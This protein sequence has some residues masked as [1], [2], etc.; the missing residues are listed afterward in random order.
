[1]DVGQGLKR[2]DTGEFFS[3]D[4]KTF[5]NSLGLSGAYSLTML[6]TIK[7]DTK[8]LETSFDAAL[9]RVPEPG[10]LALLGLGLGLV[11]VSVRRRQG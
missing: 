10:T 9:T 2:G 8:D 4:T 11:G 6:V 5:Q 1:M 3:T 7:H